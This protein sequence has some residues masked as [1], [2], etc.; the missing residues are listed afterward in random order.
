MSGSE[1]VR[2]AVA[3]LKDCLL[4]LSRSQVGRASLNAKKYTML[5]GWIAALCAELLV[6]H[7]ASLAVPPG[8][9]HRVCRRHLAVHR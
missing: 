4:G 7:T 3:K 1:S 8:G 6:L 5:L 9:F 2:C